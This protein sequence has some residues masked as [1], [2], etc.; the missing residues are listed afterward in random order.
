MDTRRRHLLAAGMAGAAST[1]PL[2]Q[3]FAMQQP[4]SPFA[5]ALIA[6]GP[7]P[8]LADRLK[9]Y[10]QFVGAWEAEGEAFLPDGS[11]RR[12]YWQTAFAWVLEGRAG[13][14]VWITPPR[15]CP[16]VGES[17]PWGPFSNQSG[18]T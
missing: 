11:R 17:Q 18:T 16:R 1:V 10:G 6:S 9:L 5:A 4:A 8:D 15:R 7:A 13:Q 12:H 3:A 14:D 2:T